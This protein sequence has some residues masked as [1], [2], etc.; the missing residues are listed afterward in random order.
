MITQEMIQPMIGMN[1]KW[2]NETT[3]RVDPLVYGYMSPIQKIEIESEGIRIVSSS[4]TATEWWRNFM[5][6]TGCPRYKGSQVVIADYFDPF[7]Q[8]GRCE[9][10]C[11]AEDDFV[12]LS[13]GRL[14]LLEDNDHIVRLFP[15]LQQFLEHALALVEQTN[16]ELGVGIGLEF[17][18]N[19]MALGARV[20]TDREVF[21]KHCH[22]FKTL[23][24]QIT[25]IQGKLDTGHLPAPSDF[26]GDDIDDVI[27]EAKYYA[28]LEAVRLETGDMLTFITGRRG[29]EVDGNQF[30]L[31]NESLTYTMLP[32]RVEANRA[33]SYMGM[34]D[35]KKGIQQ[36]QQFVSTTLGGGRW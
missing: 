1:G 7:C 28:L 18:Q 35:Y 26:S 31:P 36:M 30:H 24:P 32:H 21:A 10:A 16:Q 22:A 20:F 25:H 3:F 5:P 4:V 9:E 19:N 14:R 6:I 27:N 33:G 11:G 17:T 8:E 34:I 29:G 2:E 23:Y 12:E 15:R 13:A